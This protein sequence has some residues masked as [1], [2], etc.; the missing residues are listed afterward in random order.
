MVSLVIIL[1]SALLLFALFYR[2]DSDRRKPYNQFFAVLL[3]FA[4]LLSLILSPFSQIIVLQYTLIFTVTI[5]FIS[6][7]GYLFSRVNT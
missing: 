1:I 7:F 6:L 4:F 3:I 2:M 5:T